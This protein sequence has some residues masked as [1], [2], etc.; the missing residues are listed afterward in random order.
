MMPT[1]TA[2]GLIEY[3]SKLIR[4]TSL[5]LLATSLSAGSALAATSCEPV[6]GTL[7]SLEGLV[8]VQ[9]NAGS[10]WTSAALNDALCQG[11]T[12]RAGDRSRA[13]LQLVNQ[14]VL[15]IDQNTAMRLDRISPAKEESSFLSLVQGAF[16]SF[17]RKPRGFEV[18]TPYLNGSIEGTE[19]VL[20]VKENESELTVLEGVVVA[21]NDQ[22]SVTV[23]GGEAATAAKGQAPQSRTVV[24]PRD[25]AQWSLYYPPILAAGGAEGSAALRQA[26]S[27]LSVGRVDASRGAVDQAIAAGGADAGL[28]YALRAVINVVQNQQEQALADGSQAVSLS[29]DSTAAKIALSYAQQA[30]FQ[31]NAARDTLQA[32]VAQN[33]QDALA[34]ARLAEL[35]LMLGDRDE[36]SA[37]AQTAVGL[38]PELGR[39]QITLGFA[40]LAEF[41]NDEARG[42]FEKA[43]ALDSADPLPHLGLGLAKISDGELEAG[44]K[45]LEVAVGLDS[46]NALLRSYLGKAYFEEKR[47]PLDADQFEIA[48]Q[49]DPND[50]T[51]YLYSGIAKQTENRPVNAVKDLDRSRELNDNRAVYR[52]RLLLDKDRAARGTSLARAYKDLGFKQPAIVE[53]TQSLVIDPTNAAAHRFL[54]DSYQGV[55]RTEISRISELLQAQLLQDININP[56]QPSVSAT[57]LNIVTIGGPAGTG[58]NEF[59]PIFQRNK[60]QLNLTGFAGSNDTTGGDVVVSALYDQLSFS[61][62]AF[63]YDSDGWRPNNDVDQELYNVFAQWAVSPELNLQLEYSSQDTE[64]GD[65]A[66]N[67]DPDSFSENRRLDTD[68]DSTRIGLRYSP[69]PSS[70]FIFSYIDGERDEKQGSEDSFIDPDSMLLTTISNGA[71]LNTDG[72]LYEAQY[73]YQAEQFNLLAGG[74]YSNSDTDLNSNFKVTLE[75]IGTVVDDTISTEEEIKHSRAYIYSNIKSSDTVRWTLGASYDDFKDE[76]IKETSFNPKLGVRWDV[77]EATQL[78][79]AAFKVL[80]PSLINN[81]T[82]EPTQVAGFNQFFDDATGT[83]S[84]RYGIA[85]DSKIANNLSWGVEATWREMEQ[86]NILSETD[87]IMED[88][89]EQLHRAYVNWTPLDRLAVTAEIAYDKF[90]DDTAKTEDFDS[91]PAEVE[92]ISLP[93]GATYFHPSG[94]FGGV[95]ATY[96]DQEVTRSQNSVFPQGDDSF[97]VTDVSVGY[98]LPKRLGIASIGVKNLFDEE[99]NYRD[100]SYRE[101]SEDAT[102]GPYFPERMVMGRLTLNF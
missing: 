16:Q 89:D 66:F 57:N 32:A 20:R 86:P 37:S 55:R 7:V 91:V 72:S 29:P 48:K 1:R 63:S 96:V 14:A 65:L 10:A 94:W 49:L 59:T 75:F 82:I 76:P 25:A 62:G 6:V 42:A 92:T 51:P 90:E 15:R 52:S 99:F 98:R 87:T 56:I 69:E 60:S 73:M 61:L 77:N 71:D 11:D 23:S 27:D 4:F 30:N 9:P 67:F 8:E 80:K 101:F 44:R 68:R 17:S 45:D 85:L 93:L 28:A 2:R 84:W 53:S 26:A 50:P 3:C 19:F 21:S 70:N 64:Q 13:T 54:S 34:H 83:E 97:F 12:V 18:S 58:F 78:R 31:I 24:R 33:P 35:Q 5:G 95:R 46:N 36:A 43:I 79:A 22:G 47:A 38:A 40:A 39:T 81:R 100:D 41:R 102:T 74:A 88:Q